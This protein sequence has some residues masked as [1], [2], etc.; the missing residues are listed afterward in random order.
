LSGSRTPGDH[1]TRRELCSWISA[2]FDSPF[3][4]L[5]I[6]QL[7]VGAVP[8]FAL[9]GRHTWEPLAAINYA[10]PWG[11]QH[12]LLHPDALLTAG[13]AAACLGYTAAFLGLGYRHFSKRDL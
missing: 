5:V 9:I 2:A 13:A 8:L 11:V 1:G 3:G 10:L 6:C 12:Y 4:S 7:V